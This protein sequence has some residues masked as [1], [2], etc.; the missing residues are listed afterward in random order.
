MGEKGNQKNVEKGRVGNSIH[1]SRE[2]ESDRET[3]SGRSSQ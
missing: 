2:L 3:Y 1:S